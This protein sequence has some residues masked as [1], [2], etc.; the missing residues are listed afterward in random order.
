MDIIFAF[1]QPFVD[2]FAKHYINGCF[3]FTFILITGIV[4]LAH[5]SKNSRGE[6]TMT[7]DD[8]CASAMGGSVLIIIWPVI[9]SLAIIA[10]ICYFYYLIVG[11]I[12]KLVTKR[13]S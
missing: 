11:L 1:V 8:V 7:A 4:I 12:I 13:I 2:F 5:L 3:I 10:G 6:H 9:I